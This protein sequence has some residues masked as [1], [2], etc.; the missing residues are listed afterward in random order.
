MA[1]NILLYDADLV[2]VGK[3]RRNISSW[4]GT[5]PSNASMHASAVRTSPCSRC[6]SLI[7]REGARVMSLT[8]GR[9]KMSKSDPNEG[10]RITLDPPELIT[11]K[12]KQRRPIQNEAWSSAT[13]IDPKRTTCSGSTPS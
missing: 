12:I 8:D 5:L 2:P 9:S 10:S 11:K 13:P 7:L 4:P 3:A 1:A 6:L